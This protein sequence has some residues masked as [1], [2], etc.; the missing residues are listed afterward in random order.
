MGDVIPL[1]RKQTSEELFFNYVSLLGERDHGKD[2]SFRDNPY[3]QNS[4]EREAWNRGW[5]SAFTAS[6][7]PT[8]LYRE[9]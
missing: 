9:P 6:S 1:P 8:N 2:I 7:L 4:M 3:P 5:W